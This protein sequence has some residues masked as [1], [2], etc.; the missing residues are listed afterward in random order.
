MRLVQVT[1]EAQHLAPFVHYQL[2]ASLM[3]FLQYV[4]ARLDVAAVV[5]EHRRQALERTAPA[6]DTVSTF[7]SLPM[8]PN[9]FFSRLNELLEELI[10]KQ[11]YTYTSVFDAGRRRIGYT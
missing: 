1:H 11:S 3:Q 9:F 2:G 8:S 4:S 6:A 7:P 5:L 10:E